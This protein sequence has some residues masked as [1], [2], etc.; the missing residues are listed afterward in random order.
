MA[1][2]ALA[3]RAI[4]E[5]GAMERLQYG[6]DLLLDRQAPDGGWNYGNVRVL[7]YELPSFLDTTG[8]ALLAL[9]RARR[10]MLAAAPPPLDAAIARGRGALIDRALGSEAS[11]LALALAWHVESATT[12]PE[13]SGTI[14]DALAVS[15]AADLDASDAGYPVLET[16]TLVLSMLALSGR[17]LLD[18]L[19][20]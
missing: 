15:L 6:V 9:E 2:L 10:R 18:V 3:D 12:G 1:V 5:P 17:H 20:A 16:R 13:W 4:R 19:D 8:W 7:D 11:T 14:A